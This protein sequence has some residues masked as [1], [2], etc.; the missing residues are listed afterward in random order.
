MATISS[1]MPV[2][3]PTQSSVNQNNGNF[4]KALEG[5]NAMKG[6]GRGGISGEFADQGDVFEQAKQ[7][8]GATGVVLNPD[9]LF[10]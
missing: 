6:G 2:S 3:V 5:D 9:D 4:E 7:T 8:G 10:A 1:S